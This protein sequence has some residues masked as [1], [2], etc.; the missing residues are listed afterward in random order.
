MTDYTKLIKD[1]IES[2]YKE[3]IAIQ[4]HVCSIEEHCKKNKLFDSASLARCLN[5]VIDILAIHVASNDEL[6]QLVK[7]GEEHSSRQ[8]IIED[9]KNNVVNLND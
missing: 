5:C 9:L 6:K 2:P 4:K 1:R 3:L 8:A 7:K